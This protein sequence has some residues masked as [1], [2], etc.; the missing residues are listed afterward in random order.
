MMTLNDCLRDLFGKENTEEHAFN[1]F[2][3]INA[4][5][6]EN[7]DL[8]RHMVLASIKA[9]SMLADVNF[10]PKDFTSQHITVLTLG[11]YLGRRQMSEFSLKGETIKDENIK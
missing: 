3:E 11:I 10:N 2:K 7:D 9:W 8:L 5:V 6:F 1:E 4:E